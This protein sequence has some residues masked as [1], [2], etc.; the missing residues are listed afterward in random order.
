MGVAGVRIAVSS[1]VAAGVRTLCSGFFWC[2]IIERGDIG[3]WSVG[4]RYIAGGE[5]C[6]RCTRS[7]V[8]ESQGCAEKGCHIPARGVI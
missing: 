8:Y 1:P 3:A 4:E 2:G 5:S 7:R 6:I